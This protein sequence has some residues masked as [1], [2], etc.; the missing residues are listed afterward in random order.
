MRKRVTIAGRTVSYLEAGEGEP[1]L[2]IHAFPLSAEMWEPQL[3]AVPPGWR[4]IAPDMR[5]FGK[6]GPVGL[7]E[8][9]LPRSIDDY[10][11]DI[12][13]LLQQLQVNQ[14]VIGGLSM[15]GYIAF[16]LLRLACDRVRGLILADTRPGPDSEEGRAGRRRMQALVDREGAAGVARDMLPKLLGENTRRQGGTTVSRVGAMIE[17]APP[18]AIRSALQCLMMRPDSTPQLAAFRCPALILVGEQDV[19]TP[20]ADAQRM[21]Q[22]IEGSALVVVPSAG[23]LPNLERPAEFN[24]VVA[25]FLAEHFHR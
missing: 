21:H 16:G 19:L 17:S 10:A 14:A 24:A 23:H 25:Q 2:L 6:S 1:L 20:V 13:G 4:I 22:L 3:G 5:G 18:P 15:G 7:D 12:V 8:N 9:G 11:G